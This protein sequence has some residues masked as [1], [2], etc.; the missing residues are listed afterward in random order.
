MIASPPVILAIGDSLIAGYG[1]ARADSFPARLE[2]ALQDDHPGARVLNAGVSGAT[3]A[4][5]LADLPRRLSQFSVRPNLAIVQVGPNDVLRRVPAPTTGRNLAAI[6]T[7]LGRCG[8]P[9]LLTTVEPPAF[10]REQTRA[11]AGLHEQ[12][13]KE[14]GAAICPFFPTGVLGRAD[15]VLAD[16]IHPNANAIAMV[17][18][19]M[20]PVIERLIAGEPTGAARRSFAA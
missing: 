9:A 18:T 12:V 7:E 3:T 14:L 10:L 11:Y 19:A 17:V 15:L 5:V 16:R 8:V 1:L 2:A 13:A 6:V 4:D 20:L